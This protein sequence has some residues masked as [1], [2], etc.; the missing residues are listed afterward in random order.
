MKL[1]AKLLLKKRWYLFLIIAFIAFFMNF[2]LW[3][4]AT[5]AIRAYERLERMQEEVKRESYEFLFQSKAAPSG[6]VTPLTQNQ[7]E[8]L[9]EVLSETFF[10]PSHVGMLYSE[11][12]RYLNGELAAPARLDEEELRHQVLD[13]DSTLFLFNDFIIRSPE[14]AEM[15]TL[16]QKFQDMG[17]DIIIRPFSEVFKLE[18][19]Y[20]YNNFIFGCCVASLL[21]IFASFLIY[22]L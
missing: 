6:M 10:T 1:I 15:R 11:K 13:Q 22:R 18:R 20:Y 7:K 19:D 12:N 9:V 4:E 21:S 3:N 14:K 5:Q 16:V 17:V 2:F 8:Q